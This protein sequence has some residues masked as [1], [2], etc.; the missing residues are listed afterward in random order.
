MPVDHAVDSPVVEE[1]QAAGEPLTRAHQHGLVERVGVEVAAGRG[2]DD[3]DAH[4]L[5]GGHAL[6]AEDHVGATDTDRDQGERDGADRPLVE[7]MR[8]LDDRADR[9]SQPVVEPAVEHQQV[10]AD[11]REHR[12]HHHR[13]R[14][15]LRRFV[16]VDVV[17]PARLA[18]ERHHQRARHVERGQPRADHGGQ[19]EDPARRAALGERD[20]DDLVLGPEAGR[21]READDGEVAGEEHAERRSSCALRRPPKRRMSMRSFMACMTEPAE[22]NSAALKKPWP[23]QV[24]DADR[25]V[26]GAQADG[27]EHVADLADGRVGE[28]LL[29]VVLPEGAHAAVEQRDRADDGDRRCGPPARSRRSP[30]S[31]RSGRRR[32]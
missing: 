30:P 1:D 16:R 22:R 25:V 5:G 31:G 2:G 24:G 11:E 19:A 12:Q 27:E 15:D 3:R 26:A 6:A 13:D 20:V 17:L 8:A 14:H 9:G 29:Q 21:Q 32:R 28:D 10:T 4:R 7:R 23:E 18:E